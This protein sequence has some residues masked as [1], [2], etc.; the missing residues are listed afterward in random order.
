MSFNLS[1]IFKFLLRSHI[2]QDSGM[3][4]QTDPNVKFYTNVLISMLASVTNKILPQCP[5]NVVRNV[6]EVIVIVAV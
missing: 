4:E 6:F 2:Y 3:L 1:I 5:R